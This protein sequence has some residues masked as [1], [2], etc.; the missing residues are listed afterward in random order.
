MGSSSVMRRIAVAMMLVAVAGALVALSHSAGSLRGA[1][2]VAAMLI[3][4]AGFLLSLMTFLA[5]SRRL[6]QQNA[7]HRGTLEQLQQQRS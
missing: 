2:D 6:R 3:A 1:L 5:Q 7:A 4:V